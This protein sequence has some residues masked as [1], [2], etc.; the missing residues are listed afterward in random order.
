MSQRYLLIVTLAVAVIA[1]AGLVRGD[2]ASPFGN[3]H[4]LSFGEVHCGVD[5]SLYHNEDDADYAYLVNNPAFQSTRGRSKRSS[6]WATG[7]NKYKNN[8]LDV[9]VLSDKELLAELGDFNRVS[10]QH[11]AH[12]K[13]GKRLVLSVRH[14]L[15]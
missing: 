15:K 3:I 4:P 7:Q 11:S 14:R 5:V 13:K 8:K 2:S 1:T 12:I 6:A 9:L 10:G